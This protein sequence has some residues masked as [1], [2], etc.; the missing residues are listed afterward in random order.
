[1]RDIKIN[2]GSTFIVFGNTAADYFNTYFKSHYKNPVI[3]HYHYSHYGVSDRQW[4]E[5][6]WKKLNIN[7]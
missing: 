4:V 5:M 1:M 3:Y 7:V 2:S 6:L